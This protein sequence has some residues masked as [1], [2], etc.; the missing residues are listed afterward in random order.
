[1][2]RRQWYALIAVAVGLLWGLAIVFGVLVYELKPG[3]FEA[4]LHP[5]EASRVPAEHIYP[6]APA[7]TAT[8]ERR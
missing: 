1:M 7:S 3:L 2:T 5:W 8:G 6:P 4:R